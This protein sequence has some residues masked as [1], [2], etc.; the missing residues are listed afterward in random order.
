MRNLQL[1][2]FDQRALLWYISRASI[3][4]SCQRSK[5]DASKLGLVVLYCRTNIRRG[6][7]SATTSLW[8]G[9]GRCGLGYRGAFTVRAIRVQDPECGVFFFFQGVPLHGAAEYGAVDAA[10]V[11]LQHGAEVLTPVTTNHKPN[12]LRPRLPTTYRPRYRPFAERVTTA[13]TDHIPTA[14]RPRY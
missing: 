14:L 9:S 1:L 2:I 10:R 7:F 12:A 13:F 8:C 6:L 4:T 5:C 3:L 11:L